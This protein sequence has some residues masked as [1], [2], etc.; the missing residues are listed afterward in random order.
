MNAR[1]NASMTMTDLLR[2]QFDANLSL[3]AILARG[4]ACGTAAMVF[5]GRDGEERVL[6]YCELYRQARQLASGLFRHGLQRGEPVILFFDDEQAFVLALWAVWLAGGVAVPLSAPASYSANDEALC[7]ILAVHRSLEAQQGGRSMLVSDL[8]F[9]A[10]ARVAAWKDTVD[11]ARFLDARELQADVET[12]APS[13]DSADTFARADDLAILMFSSGSTGDPK[14]VRLTHRQI[15]VNLVQL[16]DRSEFTATDRS[17]S[18]LPLTHDM[19]LVLFHLCHTLA[20]IAQYKMTPLAFARNPAQLLDYVGAYRISVLGMPN[21]GF[22][23]L[24][25]AAREGPSGDWSLASVRL[26]Y[27]GAEPIDPQLC[28]RFAER[29]AAFA[30]PAHVINP[31]WGIAEASVAASGFPHGWLP[32]YDGVPSLWVSSGEG[33]SLG[34][35]IR[36]CQPNDAESVEIVSLGPPMADMRIR[37]LDDAGQ[38]LPASCLGHMEIQGPNVTCGYFGGPDLEWCATGDVGFIHDELV[39]LTGRAKDVLFINGRNHFSN[40]IELALCEKLQWPANQLA[41]VGVTHP[42]RRIEQVVVFFRRLRDGDTEQHAKR[43]RQTLESLLAYPVAGAIGLTALPK[44]TSGKIRRFVLRQSLLAGEYDAALADIERRACRALTSQEAELAALVRTLI[45]DPDAEIDPELPLSRYGLDS[46]GF[47]Q[48]AFR[49]AARDARHVAPQALIRAGSLESMLGVIDAVPRR[50]A[51]LIPDTYSRV[52]LTARQ[53]QLW[54]AWL[55]DPLSV[56]YNE[57]YWLRIEGALDTQAWLDAACRVIATH[58]MLR[59]VVDDGGVAPALV[60]QDERPVEAACLSCSDA[61]IDATMAG[62]AAQDFDLRRGPL[63]RLRLIRTETGHTVFL[64]AHHMVTDGWSL[65]ALISQIFAV[66]AGAAAP[67]HETGLWFEPPRFSSAQVHAWRERV[68]AAEPIQLPSEGAYSA[69]GETAETTWTLSAQ[70]S[71]AVRD[72]QLRHGS[73]FTALAA[74]LM[75]LLARL[76]GVR[77]PL[78]GTVVS[79]RHDERAQSRVGYFA[80][81]LPLVAELAP[82]ASFSSVVESLEQD[83]LVMLSGEVPDLPAFECRAGVSMAR[84]MRVVYVHQNTPPIELPDGL[85]VTGQGRYRGTARADLCVSSSWRGQ[86]VQLQWEYDG[87]RFSPAQ[88]AG[89]AELFEFTLLQLLAAP[90]RPLAQLDVLSPAQRALWRPYQDTLRAVDFEHDVVAR[91]EALAQAQPRLLA[92]SDGVSRYSYGE[93]S[94]RVD[95]L[96]WRLDELGL[97]HG[98]RVALLTERSADYVVALLASFKLAAVVIPMDPALPRERVEQ[99]LEDSGACLLLTTPGAALDDGL[100]QRYR[101]LCFHAPA[102]GESPRH[103]GRAR[104]SQDAAYLIFTSGSTGK[105]KGVFNTHRCLTNLVEWV[106]SSLAYH[107]GETICQFAPFSFDVSMA[108]ILPSLCAGLHIHVLPDEHRSSPELYLETMSAQQVNVATVTPAYLSVLNEVP[109]RCREKLTR[110]RLLIL[111]GEALKTDDVRRFREHSPH[112]AIVNVYGPTETT[113]LSSAYPL[114]PILSTRRNWQPLG[115]PI[116]NTEIWVLDEA[117]RVCP[118]TVTGT[119]YIGG[120]GLSQG[121][122]SD[123]AKTNAAFRMLSPDGQP[124]R[125]FYCS[126][127]LARLAADGELEFVGRADTQIKLRGFRIELGEIEAVLEQHPQIQLAV[128]VALARDGAEPVLVAYH[129][130]DASAHDRLDEFLR[131]R[132]P[133]YMVPAAYVHMSEWPLSA[134]RKVDRNRLPAPQW[135]ASGAPREDDVLLSHTERRLARV[136]TELLG[137]ASVG[138]RDNFALLGGSSLNAAQLV[139]RVRERFG[140]ELPLTQIMRANTL[141][142]MARAIDQAEAPANPEPTRRAAGPQTSAVA[143]EAQSRMVFLERAHPGT[144]VNNVPLTLALGGPLDECCLRAAVVALAQRH[145]MLR[146]GFRV[147]QQGVM[148]VDSAGEPQFEV[149][150]AADTTQALALLQRFHR[151]AFSLEQG[152]LWRVALASAADSGRTWLALCL[153]HAIADGVTLVRVLT[154]LDAL[155]QGQS[156]LPTDSELSYADYVAWQRDLLDSEFGERATRIWADER[157]HCPLPKLPHTPGRREDVSGRQFAIDLGSHQT[158]MLKAMCAEQRVSP[159]VLML[160]LFG[161]VLGQ[162]CNARRFSVGVTLSGRS[163]RMLETIPGMLVNTLPLAFDWSGQDRFSGLL[164]RVNAS[165]SELQDLQDFPLNR[166]MAAQKLRDTPF[167]VL[168]N[169]EMLPSE[170]HFAGVAAALEGVST[171]VAKLPLLISFLV[172]GTTWRVRFEHREHGCPPEWMAGMLD[173]TK[174]LIDVLHGMSE[175]RLDELQTPDQQLMALLELN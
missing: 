98:D 9:D 93:L 175:A 77:R 10:L 124:P 2:S 17:L 123:A 40:D 26:I 66:Y 87:L 111:G 36:V 73:D 86:R 165:L 145:A 18:W 78:L 31:G 120:E 61:N 159:F 63:L 115:R 117:L 152:P 100:L 101:S 126:G 131:E 143:S 102:L 22:D 79:G 173:D 25:R 119:L 135:R 132:L 71:Q 29:F 112:V 62:L 54:M 11:P 50:E 161:F 130:G 172:G 150:K 39:Y 160:S 8:A 67:Q 4:A 72:W 41:V 158:A 46:V 3:P 33:V 32:R 121:Y 56:A 74:A 118:A 88:I 136:W 170:L 80:M 16:C 116:A 1:E 19:G 105:P 15:L 53:N 110:L 109:Q 51:N 166:V 49:I 104:A 37:V 153:H 23:Q 148:Q 163:R 34:R 138:R 114:P 65:H 108:E 60:L 169:E 43:M 82:E 142:Q 90:H 95:A 38:V 151:R 52:P 28:R 99:I 149:L 58:S 47:M 147:E 81:T 89:Y 168:F 42:K 14:G 106:S 7:K 167:N 97:A 113:V 127:D 156:L 64:S 59:A 174:R 30:L 76:A 69:H 85:S 144:A 129:S 75:A 122:W 44:T 20:G 70:A 84:A 91:F 133:S 5:L 162:R 140:R 12:S 134:N 35:P 6:P 107:S 141:E 68:E 139:N 24:L 125:R 137:V 96:C 171:G 164:Q 57:T 27:N 146:V 155:Y 154:E 103:P 45:A 157:R 48:L 55:M 92:L 21:F 83:R 128:V 13:S 94:E